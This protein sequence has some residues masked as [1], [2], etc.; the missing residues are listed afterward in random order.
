MISESSKVI[1]SVINYFESDIN[2]TKELLISKINQSN[3]DKIIENFIDVLYGLIAKQT[4]RIINKTFVY[5]FHEFRKQK[6]LPISKTSSLAY[7]M[8]LSEMNKD[9][10]GKWLKNI[11]FFMKFCKT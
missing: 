8:F 4:W 7:E 6:G 3:G 5:E 1:E 9:V 10:I 11:P 2:K